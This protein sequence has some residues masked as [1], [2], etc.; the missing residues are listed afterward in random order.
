MFR[1]SLT[2]VRLVKMLLPWWAAWHGVRCA[3]RFVDQG[4]AAKIP[5]FMAKVFATEAAL[6]VCDESIQLLGGYGYMTDYKVEQNYRDAR[7][8]TIGE[9]TSEILRLAITASLEKENFRLDEL[10][11]PLE[12][13]RPVGGSRAAR[14]D[15]SAS[16][17]ILSLAR[18]L[19]L[20][21][22]DQIKKHE[23]DGGPPLQHQFTEF[24]I[25]RMA[26]DW[27]IATQTVNSA[28][29]ASADGPFSEVGAALARAFANDTATGISNAAQ[30]LLRVYGLWNERHAATQSEIYKLAA[31]D[32]PSEILFSDLAERIFG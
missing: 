11:A 23:N 2:Q 7:L 5:A 4:K 24:Q 1:K 21:T 31:R 28:A 16:A 6:H 10:V 22:I 27:W 30:D 13:A 17:P 26:T 25:A 19:M 32:G 9:G 20:M 14:S 29:M 12:A 18:D 15:D 3:A 8:L